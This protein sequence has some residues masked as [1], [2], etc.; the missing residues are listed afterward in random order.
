MS[1]GTVTVALDGRPTRVG[2]VRLWDVDGE[3]FR[4]RVAQA[5][6]SVWPDRCGECD[7]I[8]RGLHSSNR[9]PTPLVLTPLDGPNAREIVLGY[10]IVYPSSTVRRPVVVRGGGDAADADARAEPRPTP[11]TN[12]TLNSVLVPP[13]LRR[14][15]LGRTLVRLA[16]REAILALGY[17]CVTVW[18]QRD[19]VPF[20]EACGFEYEPPARSRSTD[21]DGGRKAALWAKLLARTMTQDQGNDDDDEDNSSYSS[22]DDDLDECMRCFTPPAP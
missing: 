20:Y 11:T 16:T 4:E 8:R 9:R 15:R 21:G 1:S 19:L 6:A 7:A 17:E 10:T 5:F 22:D 3:A 12:C 13:A 14:A 2:L 18:C